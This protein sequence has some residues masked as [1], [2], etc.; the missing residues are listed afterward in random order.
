MQANIVVGGEPPAATLPDEAA[1]EVLFGACGDDDAAWGV[2][3]I[4]PQPLAPFVTPV[5]LGGAVDAIP[6]AYVMCLRDAA[7]PP[8]LQRRMSRERPCEPVLELDTDHSPWLSCP[9][10]LADVLLRIVGPAPAPA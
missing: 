4:R 7:I 9:D 10:E 5:Q 1:R 6:R 8:P 2:A 3:R